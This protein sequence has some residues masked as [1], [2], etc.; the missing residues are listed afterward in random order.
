[1]DKPRFDEEEIA[2]FAAV[3]E[4]HD[5]WTGWRRL[6]EAGAPDVLILELTHPAPAVVR[7]AKS[8]PESYLANGLP[9]RSLTVRETL[10]DVLDTI[11][12][13]TSPTRMAG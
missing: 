11:A 5:T 2:R 7:I 12:A 3:F 9:G 8:G 10:D 4:R 13:I 6:D 1:M